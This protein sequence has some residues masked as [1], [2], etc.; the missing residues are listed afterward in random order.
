MKRNIKRDKKD[1]VSGLAAEVEQ[2]AYNGNM[3]QM[4][5]ITKQLSGR[6]MKPVRPDKD[7]QGK[8]IKEIEQQIKRWAEH[9]REL[10]NR[11]APPNPP[12]IDPAISDLPINC[13]KPTREEIRK[14]ITLLKN[15][16]PLT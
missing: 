11:P 16:K 13:N 6:F 14:S 3:K 9:F 4:Y 12:D 15:V 5:D 2:A 10:L 8:T 1:Y 7:K